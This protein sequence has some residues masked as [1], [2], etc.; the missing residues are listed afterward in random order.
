MY[1]NSTFLTYLYFFNIIVFPNGSTLSKILKILCVVFSFCLLLKKKFKIKVFFFNVWSGLLVLFS[2]VS[3]TWAS[4]KD[5]A[6]SGTGTLFLNY[7]CIFFMMQ[8]F[9]EKKENIKA[10]LN[11]A[12]LFPLF[13]FV[14]L[15]ATHGLAV[16][17][18]LRNI[19]GG[20]H[21]LMGLYAA[22]GAVFCFFAIKERI[23]T[24]LNFKILMLCNVCI[25]CLTMSRKAFLYLLIPIMIMSLFEGNLKKKI[26]RFFA[27]V[28]FFA[29]AYL[30]ITKVSFFY[31]YIG[32][33]FENML[34][35]W[36]NDTGDVSAAGR[37]TRIDFGLSMY[38]QRPL[39]GWGTLN[40]NYLFFK[41]SRD[42]DM[43]IADNNF[44][45]IL[46]NWG[47]VGLVL[48]Y[49]LHIFLMFVFFKTFFVYKQKTLMVIFPFAL[50]VTLLVCDYGVSAYLYLHS[51]TYLA[52][53][54]IMINMGS[55][56][57]DRGRRKCLL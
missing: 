47:I 38:E 51:Q 2:I 28:A 48:Y 44:V 1:L 39:L 46:V 29:C 33:G 55:N 7:L 25:C 34:S 27:I 10:V 5:Y 16:F 32:S 31:Q 57:Q 43:V 40:Y 22:F 3:I 36:L 19:V 11:A 14:R 6:V 30:L 45:D 21:N 8:M 9:V 23:E 50:L 24:K 42:T 18:G 49:S 41:S 52:L 20:S 56:E 53:V 35:F 15:F 17:G 26:F 13:M 4:S 54:T 12:S 37:R